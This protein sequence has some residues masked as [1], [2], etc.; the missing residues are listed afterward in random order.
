MK[1]ICIL[2]PYFGHFPN[3]FE[4]W[5]LSASK[6]DS[7]DYF[8]FTD[9]ETKKYERRGFLNIKFLHMEM[10]EMIDLIKRRINLYL[11]NLSPYKICDLRPAFGVIFS[12]YITNYDFWGFCD[13]DIIFGNIRKFITDDILKEYDKISCFGHFQLFKNC[14]KVNYI[15]KKIEKYESILSSTASFATDELFFSKI[16]ISHGIKEYVSRSFLCDVDYLHYSFKNA[17]ISCDHI[18]YYVLFWKDGVLFAKTKNKFIELLYC[19]LQKRQISIPN[20]SLDRAFYIVPNKIVDSLNGCR[21]YHFRPFYFINRYINMRVKRYI[22]GKK[23]RRA[24][25]NYE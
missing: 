25:R 1:K 6:N 13:I 8:V 3:F 20:V 4:Y 17:R 22:N 24:V 7:I 12:N 21:F 5:L 14:Y 9:Q 18:G 11:P 19:H 10:A 2:V 23:C 16:C 15:F